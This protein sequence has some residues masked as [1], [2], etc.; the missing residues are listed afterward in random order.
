LN[1]FDFDLT[2]NINFENFLDGYSLSS[3]LKLNPSPSDFLQSNI[4]LDYFD[5][6]VFDGSFEL[7]FPQHTEKNALILLA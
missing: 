1:L 3:K 5:E 6:M 4:L 7:K 2:D